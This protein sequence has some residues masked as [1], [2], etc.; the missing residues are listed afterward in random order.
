MKAK[1]VVDSFSDLAEL[2]TRTIVAAIE[3]EYGFTNMKPSKF[4]ELK[5][6]TEKVLI[7]RGADYTPLIKGMIDEFVE[8]KESAGT[9]FSVFQ[10]NSQL[11]QIVKDNQQ[12][13]ADFRSGYNYAVK[14]RK[15]LDQLKQDVMDARAAWKN[16]GGNQEQIRKELRIEYVQPQ[17]PTILKNLE[18]TP[19]PDGSETATGH[20]ENEVTS[21]IFDIIGG[22]AVLREISADGMEWGQNKMAVCPLPTS[23]DSGKSGDTPA[24][25]VPIQCSCGRKFHFRCYH[26]GSFDSAMTNPKEVREAA[27]KEALQRRAISLSSDAVVRARQVFQAF[28]MWPME[29]KAQRDQFEY[30]LRTAVRSY[31][32]D[33]VFNGQPQYRPASS[34]ANWIAMIAIEKH[35]RLFPYLHKSGGLSVAK[36]DSA[37]ETLLRL[38]FETMMEKDY[39]NYPYSNAPF[40]HN[41]TLTKLPTG[42]VVV[43]LPLPNVGKMIDTIRYVEPK[44]FQSTIYPASDPAIHSVITKDVQAEIEKKMQ[45]DTKDALLLLN[46]D[47]QQMVG[48]GTAYTSGSGVCPLPNIGKVE[49]FP[50]MA[51]ANLGR[52]EEDEVCNALLKAYNSDDLRPFADVLDTYFDKKV[53][54]LVYNSHNPYQDEREISRGFTMLVIRLVDRL[55]KTAD[56]ANKSLASEL[57]QR[58]DE[59][60]ELEEVKN[61]NR[62]L[63]DIQLKNSG[64]I[65]QLENKV[66]ELEKRNEGYRVQVNEQAK[67][68]H[69]MWGMSNEISYLKEEIAKY[70]RGNDYLGE[71]ASQ[72]EQDLRTCKESLDEWDDE[73]DRGCDCEALQTKVDGQMGVVD[74]LSIA[75]SGCYS[76]KDSFFPFNT[77][78]HQS[79]DKQRIVMDIIGELDIAQN[80]A[81]VRLNRDLLTT[82]ANRIFEYLQRLVPQNVNPPKEYMSTFLSGD[83]VRKML[84]KVR[85]ERH[86][87]TDLHNEL[88]KLLEEVM[89]WRNLVQGGRCEQ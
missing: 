68:I 8:L 67:R 2:L 71:R 88:Q 69:R 80:Q 13:V 63:V 84:D 74:N 83:I 46:K 45:S 17:Q 77:L 51:Y 33:I 40:A 35:K 43:T 23:T 10:L 44:D 61:R 37:L 72:L 47:A 79:L 19:L 34:V 31:A 16:G 11:Q 76:T 15:E 57:G 65:V 3:R 86:F 54:H 4:A 41:D 36:R 14:E 59:L 75:L 25:P 60:A 22:K 81:G 73:D 9:R 58:Q 55:L 28:A 12:M 7:R 27:T 30:D 5:T 26:N 48:N 70:R 29:A 42:E 39:Q 85:T 62:K 20:P 38:N 87:Y 24:Q 49:E 52:L 82:A 50:P 78:Y 66:E 6:Q 18:P 32:H 89:Y 64:Y 56:I 1:T 21:A 53:H